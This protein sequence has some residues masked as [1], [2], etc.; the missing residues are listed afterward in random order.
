[1]ARQQVKASETGRTR[2]VAYVRVS[3]EKQAG[4]GV[5]LEAQQAKIRA[6]SELYGLELVEVIVEAGLS[7]KTLDR[8]GLGRALDIRSCPVRC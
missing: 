4:H 5:S 7:A 8:P 1:M 3:T 6:Y 2:T